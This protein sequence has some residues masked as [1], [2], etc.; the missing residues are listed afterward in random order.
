[1]SGERES[2]RGAWRESY[3]DYAFNVR[4]I[5]SW[6]NNEPHLQ[7]QSKAERGAEPLNFVP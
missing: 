2:N 7:P 1:M 3:A 6:L 4:G 5:N